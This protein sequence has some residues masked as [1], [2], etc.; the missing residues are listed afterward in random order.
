MESTNGNL[1]LINEKLDILLSRSNFSYYFTIIFAI[2]S[3]LY[4]V[5][6]I[7]LNLKN[8][9][10]V[11]KISKEKNHNKQQQQQQQYINFGNM[12]I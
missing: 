5:F 4:C 12:P 10:G 9:F 2:L 6:T 11:R 1:T 7:L 8:Y 3:V